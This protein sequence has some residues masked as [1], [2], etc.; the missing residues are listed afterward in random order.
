MIEAAIASTTSVYTTN[1]KASPE[2]VPFGIDLLG[3]F[4]SPDMLEPLFASQLLV[5]ISPSFSLALGLHTRICHRW[6][7]TEF[8]KDLE[9]SPLQEVDF[10]LHPW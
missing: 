8:Q 3:F 7:E 6:Q 4:K 5:K 9:N 1:V 10:Q 2:S